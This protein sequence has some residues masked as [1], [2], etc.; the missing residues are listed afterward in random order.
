VA[1]EVRFFLRTALYTLTITVIY[2]FVSYEIAGSTLL[3]TLGLAAIFFVVV[4]VVMIRQAGKH[5]V[6]DDTRSANGLR[7][8]VGFDEAAGEGAGFPLAI[9][10]DLIPSSS[11]W[12]L[13]TAVAAFL[14]GLGLIY[15]GWM[16]GPATV[17]AIVALWGWVTQLYE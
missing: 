10:E 13:V 8:L 3:L 15:G 9:E 14:L 7:R 2:W 1:E 5:T 6:P 12:P 16:W 17:L 4:G 11:I